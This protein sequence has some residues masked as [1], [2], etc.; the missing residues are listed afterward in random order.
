RGAGEFPGM[1]S[2]ITLQ[3]ELAVFQ[4]QRVAMEHR[5]SSQIGFD[6]ILVGSAESR[7]AAEAKFHG[8][9]SQ[10]EAALAACSKV[11]EAQRDLYAPQFRQLRDRVIASRT[12]LRDSLTAWR[13]E[14]IAAHIYAGEGE[15]AITE[16]Y[17]DGRHIQ[18]D[19]T[20]FSMNFNDAKLY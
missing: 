3:S 9:Q 8:E 11:E 7:A 10:Y 20:G 16:I 12:R 2:W 4:T 19:N 14:L 5:C 18:F 13:K 15:A 6:G 1:F 17:G